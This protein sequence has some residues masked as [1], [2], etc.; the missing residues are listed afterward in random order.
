MPHWL[1]AIFLRTLNVQKI[2]LERAARFLFVEVGGSTSKEL[3]VVITILRRVVAP[4]EI[5]IREF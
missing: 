5:V 3:A 2:V 1:V 4:I